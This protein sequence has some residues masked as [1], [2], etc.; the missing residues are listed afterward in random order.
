MTS[1]EG[2]LAILKKLEKEGK[3]GLKTNYRLRDWLV[4]RQRY[5]GAPIPIIHCDHCGDVP[6]PEKDLPVRLPLGVNF[7]PDGESPLK[8]AMSLSIRFAP[9]ADVR[10]NATPTLSTPSCVRAGIS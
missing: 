3:G 5:W 4:S 7:T 1:E 9:F 2:K 8:N 10:Q 6:V